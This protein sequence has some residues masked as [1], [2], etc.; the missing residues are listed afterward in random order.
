MGVGAR[1]ATQVFVPGAAGVVCPER[2][3]QSKHQKPPAQGLLKLSQ[4]TIG[5]L[6]TTTRL[7]LGKTH[8]CVSIAVKQWTKHACNMYC[9]S[10]WEIFISVA[11]IHWNRGVRL[12]LVGA[13]R[14]TR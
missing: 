6:Q 7:S 2:Q 12:A 14:L 5:P 10:T 11:T 4:V 13:A 8:V 1:Q 3:R 9:G